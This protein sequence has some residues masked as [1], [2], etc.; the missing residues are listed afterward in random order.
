MYRTTHCSTYIIMYCIVYRTI[1]RIAY[2]KPPRT[3]LRNRYYVPYF[4]ILF[5][6]PLI[7]LT[8]TG[9][10]RVLTVQ[11]YS[12]R[13]DMPSRIRLQPHTYRVITVA[14]PVTYCVMEHTCGVAHRTVPYH[15][16]TPGY[17][18]LQCNVRCHLPPLGHQ[19]L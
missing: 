13:G 14:C 15:L 11:R 10:L 16:P 12:V 2:P 3:A 6:V 9:T 5:F 1:Y 4:V 17:K 19:Y 7:F 8:G 18:Y